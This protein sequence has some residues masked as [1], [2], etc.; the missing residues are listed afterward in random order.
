MII[1]CLLLVNCRYDP[2]N[3][4]INNNEG[5]SG[6]DNISEIN[7]TNAT[8]DLPALP[9]LPRCQGDCSCEEIIY[10]GNDTGANFLG[11]YIDT[12]L[13]HCLTDNEYLQDCQLG[14]DAL[15]RQGEITKIGAGAGSFDFTKIAENGDKLPD[16]A[17]QWQC[18]LDNH[19]GLMWEVK[20]PMGSDNARDANQTYTWFNSQL[21]EYS[22]ANLGDCLDQPNCDTEGFINQVNTSGLC[23]FYDWR[24]PTR[25]ELHD[26]IYYGRSSPAIDINYFPHGP[27]NPYWS[28]SIDTDDVNSLWQ[29]D[30]W[31]GTAGGRGSNL[32][33]SIRLVRT[34]NTRVLPN[35]EVTDNE[36]NHKQRIRVSP[37]QRCNPSAPLT[38]PI[39]RFKRDDQGNIFDKYTGLVWQPCVLGQFGDLC[40]EGSHQLMSWQDAF[41]AAELANANIPDKQPKWRLPNIKELQITIETQCEEPAL[42]PFVF[43]NVPMTQVWSATPTFHSLNQSY[44]YQYQNSVL[45]FGDR[46]DLHAVHLVR[47]C[48]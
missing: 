3:S 17:E 8:T 19:I 10:K 18:V 37:L 4:D 15:Y 2:I 44:H 43:P 32:P 7:N 47:N 45:S 46:L 11:G 14:R 39:L 6:S 26:L 36:T 48:Q 27:S 21:L 42:N 31:F 28:S 1:N 35:V 30:F 22:T 29:V 5:D 34:A 12:N 38:S 33:A 24:L 41:N 9:T 13:D 16:N 23:G 20:Q 25:V 40:T